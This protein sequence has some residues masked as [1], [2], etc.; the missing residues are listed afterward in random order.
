MKIKRI[1]SL[2][3]ACLLLLSGCSNSAEAEDNSQSETL[4]PAEES[5]QETAPI[6]T[7]SADEVDD[8]PDSLKY[9]DMDIRFVI[10][11]AFGSFSVDSIIAEEDDLGDPVH[12]AVFKRNH[13]VNERLAV[14]ITAAEVYG[15]TEFSQKIRNSVQ[16]NS[17]DFD[18]IA[19]TG[20]YNS[21]LAFDRILYNLDN[22]DY[23]DTD[24]K[25][26]GTDFINDFMLGDVKP[27]VTGD[28]TLRYIGGTYAMFVNSA[29]WEDHYTGEN[30]YDVVNEGKW[31]LDALRAYTENI[32]YD[33]NADGKD[34]CDDI[35]GII[36]N[37]THSIDGFAAGAL[38]KFSEKDDEGIPKITLPN[39]HTYNV[40]D[41]LFTVVYND[42]TGF[43]QVGDNE[44]SVQFA[45]GSAMF[46]PLR[47]YESGI[48]LRSM[49][50]D[51][52]IIPMPKY[53]EAQP[54]YNSTTH[55]GLNVYGIPVTNEDPDIAG[56]VLEVMAAESYAMVTPVFYEVA[57]KAKY[58]RDSQSGQML[59]LIREHI[60]SDFAGLYSHSIQDIT[61]RIRSFFQTGKRDY[62]SS[63]AKSQK[64]WDIVIK[65]LVKKIDEISDYGV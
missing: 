37:G 60:S 27:W 14:N 28:I 51:F 36:S 58:V 26:W 20:F 8:I 49:E 48:D 53:D 44:V 39:E 18:I 47:I 2:V 46:V 34:D 31:T 32:Y 3:L 38:L 63:L 16:S 59:D 15:S 50:D 24:K 19:A 1:T 65:N 25:Y 62:A 56:S 33:K 52:M 5:T 12:E 57:L 6:E 22:I 45:K 9:D 23:I 17:N 43:F 42:N 55:D 7:L 61:W 40:L 10:A 13:K 41:K 35:W 4:I 64:T 21:G 54:Y 30:I 11:E 29:L